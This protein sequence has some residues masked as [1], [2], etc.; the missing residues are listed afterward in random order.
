[1]LTVQQ[2]L[3]LMEAISDVP[4][5][6]KSLPPD[7]LVP[8]VALNATL[9]SRMIRSDLD[10]LQDYLEDLD[11]HLSSVEHAQDSKCWERR[12][13]G[14]VVRQVLLDKLEQTERVIAAVQQMMNPSGSAGMN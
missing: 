12:A 8:A 2:L 10:T 13:E 4:P 3:E 6:I 11:K 7:E 1:M 9:L 5:R 14:L